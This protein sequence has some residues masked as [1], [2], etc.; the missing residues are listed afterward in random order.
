MQRQRAMTYT[1]TSHISDVP[2]V[3]DFFH[4]LVH[5]RHVD[6]YP[7]DHFALYADPDTHV[8]TFTP[9][10]V[11]LHNRLMAECFAICETTDTDIYELASTA[12]GHPL[13]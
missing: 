12:L 10:E 8:P 9:R 13:G 2:D 3:Q 1:E 4:Y 7:N 5:D 11:A 6:F